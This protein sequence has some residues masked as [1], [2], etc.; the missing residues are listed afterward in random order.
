M[1]GEKIAVVMGGPSLEREVSLK[2]G[3]RVV[4]ALEARGYRTLALDVT[5]DLVATLRSEKPDAVHIALHGRFG[6]DGTIQ[7]VL[8]F[9]G[10]PYTGPGVLACART[11][12]KAVAKR[13]F[14]AE[15]VPTPP[16][17]TLSA[18]AFKEMGAATA[19]DA[20][21]AATGG[22]PAVV[23]PAKQG[24]AL[25]LTRISSAEG[26]PDALLTALSYSDKAIVERWVEGTEIAVSVLDAEDGA[27][28]LP[29]VEMAPK[30][31]IFDFNAMYTEG[32]TEY[33]VPARLSDPVLAEVARLAER[34]HRVLGGRDV[35]RVDMVVNDRGPWVLEGNTSPGMTEMSLLPM[36]AENAGMSFEDLV[37]RLVRAAL[38]R[39]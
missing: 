24:S 16:W 12:D 17:A 36:A 19:L 6:E 27:E 14:V 35:T 23:K 11:W 22:F 33:F 15:D 13:L 26:L 34:V 25:G 4:A 28:I 2:S 3:E 9:L 18:G 1:S 29:P 5:P 30:S 8:D 38:S 37:E 31:G 20:I 21:P 39:R 32:E 7:E 10:I